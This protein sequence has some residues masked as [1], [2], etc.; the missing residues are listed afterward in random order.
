[1]NLD[2]KVALI[3]GGARR[4]GRALTLALARHKSHVAIHFHGD[5]AEAQSAA[6]EAREFGVRAE[7]LWADLSQPKQAEGLVADT[8]EAFGRI[9]I[10]INNAAVYF[11]TPLGQVT[12]EQWDRLLDL[13]LRGAFFCA[14]AAGV[15]MKKQGSGKIVNIADVAALTPWP[16]YIPYCV[17]KAG[18]IA[19]THGMAKA[20]APEVTVNA[21][22]PG[23]VLPQEHETEDE[24]HKLKELSLLKRI[25]SPNDVV[26]AVLFL[27]EGS[28]FV[29]GGVIP[30]DG[31]RL[32]L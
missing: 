11:R 24:L 22:A 27:L 21:V 19:M 23:T 7:P 26:A 6:V 10:L 8:V 5:Q 32:L 28:D 16:A 3:T 18:L 15:E 14:Q 4:L 9:D 1:M 20:L 13:N 30:V 2:G 31:G 25:G 29:T 17:S 12:R